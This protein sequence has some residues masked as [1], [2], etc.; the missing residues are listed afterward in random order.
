MYIIYFI[1]YLFTQS[2]LKEKDYYCY[3]YLLIEYNLISFESR[4]IIKKYYNYKIA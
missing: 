1:F 2:V 3:H 4:S